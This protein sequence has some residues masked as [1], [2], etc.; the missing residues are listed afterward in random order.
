MQSKDDP[1]ASTALGTAVR[2][3]EVP[4]STT[5]IPQGGLTSQPLPVRCPGHPIQ[6]MR[7]GYAEYTERAL[8]LAGL[9]RKVNVEAYEPWD[10]YRVSS[11]A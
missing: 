11:A 5:S 2:R 1:A 10:P 3:R 9:T 8:E 4:S 7:F 6:Y